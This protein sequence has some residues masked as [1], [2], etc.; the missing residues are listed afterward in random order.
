MT[1]NFYFQKLVLF[2]IFT[3]QVQLAYSQLEGLKQDSLLKDLKVQ[4]KECYASIIK[5]NQLSNHSYLAYKIN[6]NEIGNIEIY[7]SYDSVSTSS[8]I[9]YKYNWNNTLSEKKITF[10]D[11]PDADYVTKFEYDLKG[12]KIFERLI[13]GKKMEVKTDFFYSNNGLLKK[14]IE[15]YFIETNTPKRTDKYFYDHK[16]RLIKR[17]A[18]GYIYVANKMS[19]DY[20]G[21]HIQT[22]RINK[23]GNKIPYLSHEYDPKNR[24]LKTIEY[25]FSTPFPKKDDAEIIKTTSYTYLENNLVAT[26]KVLENG[27]LVSF[28]EYEYT[29]FEK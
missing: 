10:R 14:K 27:Y 5:N 9:E 19:Y 11:A 12:I 24:L 25:K 4:S 13:R 20:T 6:Y 23:A 1:Q 15:H 16:N 21:N 26:K 3:L 17:T 29:F 28:W 18:T 7:H 22:I 2:L 8:T